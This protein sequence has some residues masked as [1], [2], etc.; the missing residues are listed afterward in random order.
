MGWYGVQGSKVD[1]KHWADLNSNI[2]ICGKKLL[3]LS[4]F[5]NTKVKCKSC[6]RVLD[7]ISKIKKA[8]FKPSWY[9]FNGS[10]VLHYTT[11]KGTLG[12]TECGK[13]KDLLNMKYT[14]KTSRYCTRCLKKMG[15]KDYKTGIYLQP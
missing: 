4:H 3:H 1:A 14:T 10:M 7:R 9:C 11:Q 12:I 2:T 15:Y 8:S 13:H 6:L 5:T